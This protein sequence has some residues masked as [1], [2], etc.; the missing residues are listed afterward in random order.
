MW[1]QL[2]L[3]ADTSRLTACVDYARPIRA[4]ATVTL[5]NEPGVWQVRSACPLAWRFRGWANN[6]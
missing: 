6:I 2:E 5:R 3:E 1:Q 4:G